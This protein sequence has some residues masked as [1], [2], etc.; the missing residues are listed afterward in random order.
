[1]YW[2]RERVKLTKM[3]KASSVRHVRSC[4]HADISIEQIGDTRAGSLNFRLRL[5][6]RFGFCVS[7]AVIWTAI[8]LLMAVVAAVIAEKPSEMLMV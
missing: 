6:R 2:N 1:M 8:V 4:A 3:R 7:F 5:Y